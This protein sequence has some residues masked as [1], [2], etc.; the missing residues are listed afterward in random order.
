MPAE[1]DDEGNV[2][3][4]ALLRLSEFRLVGSLRPGLT[5]SVQRL[6]SR[7]GLLECIALRSVRTME[8]YPRKARACQRNTYAITVPREGDRRPSC[9]APITAGATNGSGAM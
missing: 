3:W 5:P 2:E 6:R 9:L 8:H 7:F 1:A 4:L